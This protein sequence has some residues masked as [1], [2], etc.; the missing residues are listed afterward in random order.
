MVNPAVRYDINSDIAAS[1]EGTV[2]FSPLWDKKKI[3]AEAADVYVTV[4]PAIY[5]KATSNAEVSIWGK[6]SS[7]TD[8][9]HHAVGTGVIF[10]F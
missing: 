3:G 9:E 2:H 6:I 1:V 7:D 5:L 10:N 4:V 8:Q